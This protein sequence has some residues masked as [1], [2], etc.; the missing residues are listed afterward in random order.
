MSGTQVC[1]DPWREGDEDIYLER[2]ETPGLKPWL[3]ID[4]WALLVIVPASGRRAAGLS[5][6]NILRWEDTCF[7]L[8]VSLLQ[9][10]LT[11]EGSSIYQCLA[12]KDSQPYTFCC[13]MLELQ[14]SFMLLQLKLPVL[15]LLFNLWSCKSSMMLLWTSEPAA[16]QKIAR[17]KNDPSCITA[18]SLPSAS[19]SCSGDSDEREVP[20]FI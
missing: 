5:K 10:K 4:A 3:N 9:V 17:I 18:T 11:Q 20:S 12:E 7:V 16:V 8:P 13:G 19:F 6:I 2:G 1:A 15:P 14:A